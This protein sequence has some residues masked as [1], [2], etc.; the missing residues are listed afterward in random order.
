[1]YPDE[2]KTTILR[3]FRRSISIYAPSKNRMPNIRYAEGPLPGKPLRLPISIS[4]SST[5]SLI[6]ITPASYFGQSK[7]PFFRSKN[8]GVSLILQESKGIYVIVV[9]AWPLILTW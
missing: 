4:P 5:S 7:P 1:M 9:K 3:L 8:P 6:Y 2:A